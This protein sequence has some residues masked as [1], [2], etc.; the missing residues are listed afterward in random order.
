MA[1]KSFHGV[2]TQ[3]VHSWEA[4]MSD[5]A[6]PSQNCETDDDREAEEHH[7][8]QS[9][10]YSVHSSLVCFK[11]SAAE[12]HKQMFGLN[13]RKRGRQKLAPK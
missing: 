7:G 5:G 12:K 4:L 3:N 6:D 2:Y 8:I 1:S 13:E 11:W 9:H 10:P